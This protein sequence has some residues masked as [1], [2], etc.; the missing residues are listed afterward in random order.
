MAAGSLISIGVLYKQPPFPVGSK[1]SLVAYREIRKVPLTL[2]AHPADQEAT[3]EA[4]A[5]V[6]EL[7]V[8]DAR[9]TVETQLT[10]NKFINWR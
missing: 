2:V 5:G 6:A 1:T 4:I 3:Y 10:N 7:Q 8:I 9:T